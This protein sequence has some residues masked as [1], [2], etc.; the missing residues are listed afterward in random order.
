MH[1][2]LNAT[3]ASVLDL[4]HLLSNLVQ[5][6]LLSC[7]YCLNPAVPKK[8]VGMSMRTTENSIAN[9]IYLKHQLDLLSKLSAALDSCKHEL[10][11]AVISYLFVL[12][13]LSALACAKFPPSEP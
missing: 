11:I 13:R 7:I 3:L 8:A 10:L 2:A 4:D 6:A 1:V 12:R 9:V 5:S